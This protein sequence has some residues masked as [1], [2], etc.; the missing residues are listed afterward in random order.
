MAVNFENELVIG[1]LIA[2]TNCSSKDVRLIE[3]CKNTVELQNLKQVQL[4]GETEV[5]LFGVDKYQIYDP[6]KK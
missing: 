5:L 4:V 1:K 3:V 2:P 6:F